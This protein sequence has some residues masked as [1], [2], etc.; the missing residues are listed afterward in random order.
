MQRKLRPLK[1]LFII[2]TMTLL[3]TGCASKKPPYFKEYYDVA[4]QKHQ[5][6]TATA[7]NQVPEATPAEQSVP[8][9]NK[10]VIRLLEVPDPNKRQSVAIPASSAVQ[11]RAVPDEDKVNDIDSAT[12]TLSPAVGNVQISI[13]N[14]PLYDFLSLALGELLKLNF[15]VGPDI[16]TAPEKVTLHMGQAVESKQFLLQVLD[17]AKKNQIEISYPNNILQ[18]TKK[19]RPSP[20]FPAMQDIKLYFGNEVP[21]LPT[22]QR[23]NLIMSPS[24]KQGSQLIQL[25]KQ[26]TSGADLKLEPLPYSQAILMNGTVGTLNRVMELISE[27]DRA[28][29]TNRQFKLVYL[30]YISVSEFVKRLRELLPPQGIQIAYNADQ[31]GLLTIAL[32]KIN[33]VLLASPKEEWTTQVLYWKN[34]LD[35]PESLG[36]ESQLFVFYPKNRPADEL[37]QILSAISG[38]G[39]QSTPTQTQAKQGSRE[40]SASPSPSTTPVA[41]RAPGKF[42][43][44]Q[45]RGRNAIIISSSPSNYKLVKNMLIQLDT[46]PKQVL[47]EATIMEVTLTDQFQFG[48]EWW[49]KNTMHTRQGDFDWALGTLGNLGLGGAGLNYAVTKLTGDFRAA[50]NAYAKKNLI[51]VVSTP[52]IVV[53]D[54]KEATINVG[55]EVPVVTSETSAPDVSSSTSNPS[56]LRNIQYRNTGVIM[57]VKPVVNSEGLLTIDI[58]QELSEPQTNT[59]SSID[60]PMILNRSVHT[61]LVLKSG[62]TVMLGGLIS[63]NKSQTENKVPFFG[64]IPFIGRLFKTDSTGKTKTELIIQITPYILGDT[65]M[66]DTVT[67]KFKDEYWSDHGDRI[68]PFPW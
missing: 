46:Q 31:N 53:L 63:E 57:R 38:G 66:L 29:Y 15:M 28:D 43:A 64:D 40:N 10:P 41:A 9:E 35:N 21:N 8:I 7:H 52:H 60:S 18:L 42:S 3:A 12:I 37:V 54:G 32:D 59:A 65:D 5:A 25:I 23:I 34:I 2:L 4:L 45:D 6:T 36:D 51:N 49:L 13:E 62:E 14:M 68:R 48:V 61:S 24:T 50:V 26:F 16:Q 20:A 19:G 47:I 33:A 67:R 27:L 11:L 56:I 1:L 44:I 30:D 55:T 17:I 58:N 22:N 39:V